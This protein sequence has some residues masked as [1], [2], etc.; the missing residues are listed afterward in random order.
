YEGKHEIRNPK[1]ETN[2]KSEFRNPRFEILNLPFVSDFEFRASDVLM[3]TLLDH[4]LR[5]FPTAK[6]TTLRRM[7]TEGRVMVNGI[8]ATRLTHPV[9]AADRVKVVAPKRI[10]PSR[11]I[12]PLIIVYED[13]DLLVVDK[14]AG[15][16]TS[17]V[18]GEKRPT[19]LALVRGY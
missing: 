8:R 7:L 18:A 13:A 4:L 11:L 12:V 14:P 3:P 9:G 2:L 6:R 16:L 15:L 19:A 17:T 10:D 1:S 5:E